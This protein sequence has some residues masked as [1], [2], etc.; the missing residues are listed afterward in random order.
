M[1]HEIE[2]VSQ[3][4]LRREFPE[5]PM[6]MPRQSLQTLSLWSGLLRL[7]SRAAIGRT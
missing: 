4:L 3:A 7:L 2:F 5:A 1:K 6:V